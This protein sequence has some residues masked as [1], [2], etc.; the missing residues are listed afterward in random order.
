M[1]KNAMESFPT[2]HHDDIYD[3]LYYYTRTIWEHEASH[4]IYAT[5]YILMAVAYLYAY[6]DHKLESDLKLSEKML[7]VLAALLYAILIAGVAG[8]W[9]LLGA[10]NNITHTL[11]LFL[12][13]L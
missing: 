3:D 2:S 8:E 13:I 7:I 12:Y 11:P 9:I 5:G 10:I 6:K 1:F 4:Y